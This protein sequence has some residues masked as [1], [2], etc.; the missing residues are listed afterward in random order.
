MDVGENLAAEAAAKKESKQRERERSN[1][2]MPK[3]HHATKYFQFM[4]ELR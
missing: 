1:G 4:V 2:Q 3:R